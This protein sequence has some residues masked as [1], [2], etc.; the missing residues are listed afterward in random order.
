[1]AV[2]I[3]GGAGYIGAHTVKYFREKYKEVIVVDCLKG[4]STKAVENVIFYQVDIR[5]KKALQ[6]V[7]DHHDIE[8]VIHFAADSLV[9]ESMENPIKYYNNNVYGMMCLLEV[10]QVNHVKKIVF[11]SSASVYGEPITVP[12]T[13]SAMAIPTNTYG[14]TKLA[15]E[16]MMKW[17]DTAYG[18]KYVSLRYFNASGAHVS[19][20]I[21]ED[22]DPE[23][24]L[25]PL[26]LKVALGKNQKITIFG[27]DYPTKDGTCIRDYI[28][29]V[30]LAAAHFLAYTYLMTDGPSEIFNLGSG[31]G[32]SVNEIVDIARK[33]TG[34]PIPAE[35]KGRRHG[36][37][38]VLIA[39][40]EKAMRVLGWHPEFNRV[41]IMI[42][43]AWCWHQK[44]PE[45]YREQASLIEEVL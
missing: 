20:E 18:I 13:E 16:K 30:D 11:S 31:E 14:E 17:F 6:K 37:P 7:F 28:H 25:I 10:M 23:T 38:A 40:S 9:A 36:D 26:I 39:S 4:G 27:D 24:H 21:G 34:H 3:T 8:A 41:E 33:I 2:L 1:M 19:G 15:I 35:I 5:E 42:R 45:G 29:V 43:D 12:I 22:H 32:Y 44:H